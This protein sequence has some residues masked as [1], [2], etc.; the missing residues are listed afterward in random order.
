M[1]KALYFAEWINNSNRV[2]TERS[3]YEQME[4]TLLVLARDRKMENVVDLNPGEG[5]RLYSTRAFEERG[6]VHGAIEDYDALV[7]EQEFT[8]RLAQRDFHQQTNRDQRRA[9]TNIDRMEALD[10]LE[11][12]YISELET[13]GVSRFVIDEKTIMD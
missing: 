4:Q 3:V 10:R 6:D 1:L 2:K 12:E 9:M 5:G 13:H 11:D 7:F 8:A